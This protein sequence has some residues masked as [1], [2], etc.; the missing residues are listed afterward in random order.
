MASR[1]FDVFNGDADGICA[2][3]QWRLAYPGESTLV[4]GV[5]RDVALLQRVASAAGDEVTVLDIAIDANA[6]PLHRILDAGAYVTWFDHHS[7]RQAFT[8]PRL[9]LFWDDAPTMCTS[10]LV[11]C[12]LA[13]R[14]RPW[15]IAAAFGDNLSGPARALARGMHM[16]EAKIASLEELGKVLNYNAY[17]ER[18]E[19]LRIAPEALYRLLSPFVDPFEFIEASDAY[20]I[21]AEGYCDDVARIAGLQPQWTWPYGAVY[22][23][24]NADWARRVSGVL[25]NRLAATDGTRAF[26]VLT[27]GSD[28]AFGVSVRSAEPSTH[29]ADILC[30]RFAGGGRRTAAGINRLPAVD[31]DDFVRA[32]SDYFVTCGERT[33]AG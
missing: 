2:Q 8:H 28:G 22:V 11:D 3:H 14:Y 13:G 5:K 31:V 7:A 9:R 12:R 29:A 23:L 33:H 10:L 18:V 25:A 17:G 15:A 6:V 19:D 32:F 1:R 4:T 16:S 21:L 20:R 24:P 30:E 26:A 27:E